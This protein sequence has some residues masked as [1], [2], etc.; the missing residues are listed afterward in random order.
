ME[1]KKVPTY[2]PDCDAKMLEAGTIAVKDLKLQLPI[3]HDPLEA[4]DCQSCH[5]R[6][7]KVVNGIFIEAKENGTDK[8]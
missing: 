8:P 5:T 1:T 6:Y 7:G 4:F 3:L 2:C